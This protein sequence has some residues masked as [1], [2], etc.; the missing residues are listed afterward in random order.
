MNTNTKYT[1]LLVREKESTE[2]R[3]VSIENN[4]FGTYSQVCTDKEK[5]RIL[6]SLSH[7]NEA[8]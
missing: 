8:K 1:I 6:I 5:R 3:R 7:N 2:Y 4:I